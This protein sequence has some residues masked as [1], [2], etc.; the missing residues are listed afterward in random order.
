M[1]IFAFYLFLLC[2][3]SLLAQGALGEVVGTVLSKVDNSPVYNA[4]V[5]AVSNGTYYR[6]LTDP[7]GRFRISAIPSGKYY[8]SVIYKGDTMSNIPADISPNGIENLGSLV[9]ESK[10]LEIEAADVVYDTKKIRLKYG[11]N[12]EVKIDHTEISRSPQKFDQKAMIAS[13]TSD[14]KLTDDGELVFRGA[15]K[16]DM[17]YMM[18]GVKTTSIVAVPS[19]SIGTMM[20]YSGG[21]PA[22]YG[23]TVGGVVVMETLSYFD[24]YRIWEA[25]QIRNSK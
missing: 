14:V 15:R 16:G 24:L 17:V 11:V 9:F 23:D 13:M 7:D 19:A 8:F 3:G 25:Q 2:S 20:V 10:V 22:K 1:K 18:D 21:L 6:A 12:P 5:Q 4:R